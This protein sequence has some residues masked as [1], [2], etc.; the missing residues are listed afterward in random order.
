MMMF[1]ARKKLPHARCGHWAK[2]G[3]HTWWTYV[4]VYCNGRQ[5]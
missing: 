3:A 5:L 1:R 2:H 4:Q